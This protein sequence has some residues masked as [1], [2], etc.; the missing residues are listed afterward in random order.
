[1]RRLLGPVL[2][3]TAVLLAAPTAARADTSDFTF[4][5]Y[6][7]D[8]TLT[9]L[10][11][12]TSHLEVVETIVAR[13]PD[14]DQNRGIVRAI[15]D[16]YDGVDLGTR[17]ASVTDENGDPVYYE[18]DHTG[19]FVE[20]ALG[21]DEFVHG[22][23]TYVITYSQ[24]NVV[25]SFDDTD[26]DEFYWDLNGTGWDQP[27]GTVSGVL[28]VDPSLMSAL[29]GNDACYAGTKDAP[30]E[31][32]VTDLAV[33]VQDLAPRE[34]VTM[35]I[36]FEKGTFVAPQPT[37]NIPL[38]IPLWLDVLSAALGVLGVGVAVLAVV[39]RV[40]AGR[41]RARKGTVIAQY[42][43]PD[44]ITIVQSAHLVNRGT[45]AIPAAIVRLAVRKNLRILAYTVEGTDEPYSLQFLTHDRANPEDMAIL[46]ILFGQSPAEGATTPFGQSESAKASAL[47]SLSTDAASSLRTEGYRERPGGLG[48][49][50]ALV[51]LQAVLGIVTIGTA[52]A[53]F[54][55]FSNL[56]LFIVPTMLVGT[57]AFIV[58]AIAAARPLRPTEKGVT[59][60]TFLDGLKLYLT[61]AEEDR[62]RILQSPG[63]AERVDV[64][65]NQ[66]MIKLYEK[67][68][69]WAVLWGVEREWAKELALRVEAEPAVQNDWWVGQT[70]FSSTVFSH[71]VGGFQTAVTPPSS[72]SNGW[73]GSSMGSGFGGGS[74]GGGFAGGGGG[75]GGGGG[76]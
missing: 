53:S 13:F 17:V 16:D 39:A 50:L 48:T 38:P 1:M 49:G 31:C 70:A 10:A 33:S 34:T 54:G 28:H 56:S 69:P 8:Y 22:V 5:S 75:G 7:A 58:T 14:F 20:L 45:S 63:G 43:E 26:S 73:S 44:E 65:D 11:D 2:L 42:S 76:R 3:L 6:H 55:A 23:V 47:L 37:R 51:A 46:A 41:G 66:Q 29:S 24:E 36:G 57:V 68:L 40:R 15:P 27:F 72:S 21:T 52:S 4:D 61:V 35:S 67:L 32:A 60:E 12:G 30:R 74:F 19:D 64:D 62:L 71:A 59:A 25:R 18:A 9:R